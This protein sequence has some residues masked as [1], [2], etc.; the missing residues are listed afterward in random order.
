[1]VDPAEDYNGHQGIDYEPEVFAIHPN[2]HVHGQRRHTTVLRTT[3][4]NC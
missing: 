4:E 1:M 2:E 3:R